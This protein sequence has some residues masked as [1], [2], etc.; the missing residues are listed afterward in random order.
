MSAGL[1]LAL[2]LGEPASIGPDLTLAIWLKRRALDLPAFYVVG[3]VAFLAARA[4]HLGLD[5]PLVPVTPAEANAA[6]ARAPKDDAPTASKIAPMIPPM[7][8]APLY[9]GATLSAMT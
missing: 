7:A 2:T 9:F 1:P 6:F 4:K 3:D 5:V 8:T